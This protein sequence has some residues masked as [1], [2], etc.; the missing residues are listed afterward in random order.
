MAI[1]VLVTPAALA[2]TWPRVSE[3]VDDACRYSG[4]RYE[5]SDVLDQVQRRAW[6]LWIAVDEQGICAVAGT[7]IVEYPR[8]KAINIRF[9][10]GRDRESW[11]HFVIDF[12]A[13]GKANGCALI[14]GDL[15]KGWRRIFEGW[16]HTHDFCERTI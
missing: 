14:E 4:G 16:R 11:Q 13:F 6:H 12:I 15:R 7:E 1:L 9:G 10:T 2:A 8:L 3:M 5:A